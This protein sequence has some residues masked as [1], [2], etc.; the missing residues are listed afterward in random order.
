MG[1]FLSLLILLSA[2][3]RVPWLDK[4]PPEL[5]GDEVD[6]GYQAYSLLKTGRDLYNQP[7]PTY[8]HSLA[9]WRAPLLMYATV[10]TIAAFG[11]NEWG[12][13][14]PQAIFGL[15]APL[16]LFLLVYRTSRVA[17]LSFFCAF[18]LAL[19]PW[20]IHYSRVA[21]EVI[22]MLDLILLGTLLFLKNRFIPSALCFALSLY[23]YSTAALFVP[24]LIITLFLFTRA[25]PHRFSIPVF[26]LVLLPFIGNLLT[27]HAS[28]RFG[29]LSVFN[30]PE[31]IKSINSLRVQD[32]SSLAP[33]WHNKIETYSRSLL[34]NY[35]RAYSS[36][37]LFVR[38]DPVYRHSIQ[39]IGQLLPI[40]APL[41]LLGLWYLANRR[42][43]LWLSWFVL[44]PLPAVLT[45]DGGFHAT[46]LFLTV[47]PLAVATGAGLYQL[48]RIIPKKATLPLLVIYSFLFV[49]QFA[50]VAHYY[51]I[52]YS[53]D[54]WRW[55][56]VGYK[57]AMQQLAGQ[58]DNYGRV[59]INNSY[60]PSLIR[61]L[62]WTAYPPAKFH[63][64]FVID[65]PQD[66]IA[67][68]YNGFSLD[69]KYF[70]GNFNKSNWTEFLLP[71][72]LYLI[73]QRDNVAG[74]WD[75]RKTPPDN[76]RVLHAS[77]NAFD[78]PILYL[79]TKK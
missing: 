11:N 48:I 42:Q 57:S 50:W 28:D 60:E 30:S 4:A 1:F 65:Q 69:G 37:F 2:L 77:T 63:S 36:E 55:W 49:F 72:S 44:A 68:N 9:E 6:V 32:A 34:D 70:F 51:L 35:L 21:F 25:R 20:H 38:G 47:P 27:G 61:F 71:N 76:I 43:W 24:L 19:M 54:S 12:V 39:V 10:P 45:A 16:I 23:T 74:D 14:L 64:Q 52:H 56:H 75:W 59:F 3:F 41:V 18:A 15:L 5:F 62:F 73:S 13:R 67:P 33:F 78:S 26:I 40:T 53:Q 7:L 8:I 46:R 79:I 66:N 22:I 29:L 17:V 31:L 58:A